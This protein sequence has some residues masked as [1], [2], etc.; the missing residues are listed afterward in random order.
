VVAHAAGVLRFAKDNLRRTFRARPG[1]ILSLRP[2]EACRLNPVFAR[3]IW[4]I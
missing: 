4:L 3:R 1:V 2:G